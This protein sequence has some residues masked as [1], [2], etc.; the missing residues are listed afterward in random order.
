MRSVIGGIGRIETR[1]CFGDVADVN[2]AVARIEPGVLIDGRRKLPTG[3][4]MLLL[5][6][7]RPHPPAADEL[8]AFEPSL[9]EQ[10]L[11]PRLELLVEVVDE[12]G[13]RGGYRCD[14]CCGRLVQLA[15]ASRYDDRPYVEVTAA[16]SG[17]HVSD[18]T[19]RRDDG[20]AVR[21]QH[22]V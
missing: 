8:R 16:D 1:E 14:I 4:R 9:L 11:E 22:R 12:D 10:R 21:R 6:G 20:D 5:R 17:E 7:E 18:D 3:N 2:D 13:A 19:E 15:I